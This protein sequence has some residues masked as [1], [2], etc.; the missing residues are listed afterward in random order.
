MILSK[1]ETGRANKYAVLALKA[2]AASI[3]LHLSS[4]RVKPMRRRR[5]SG[6]SL[7][8]QQGTD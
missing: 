7:W 3:M 1:A 4:P 8:L 2:Q 6:L 5:I